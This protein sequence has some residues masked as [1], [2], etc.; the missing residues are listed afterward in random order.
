MTGPPAGQD[1]PEDGGTWEPGTPS[2]KTGE[3]LPEIPPQGREQEGSRKGRPRGRSLHPC[4]SV[5]STNSVPCPERLSSFPKASI[6]FLVMSIAIGDL[7][8]PIH[9]RPFLA[10]DS[11][12]VPEP[13][14][15]S[16]TMLPGSDDV[17]E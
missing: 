4:H 1:F 9:L 7:S 3:A 13:Q 11:S 2:G 16:R 10:A 14:N 15:A 6:L 8:M 17:L 12:V 5:R